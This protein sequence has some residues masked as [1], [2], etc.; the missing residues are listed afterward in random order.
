MFKIGKLRCLLLA[1][2]IGLMGACTFEHDIFSHPRGPWKNSKHY[3]IPLKEGQI[4]S[5]DLTKLPDGKI[6]STFAG[7]TM[8]PNFIQKELLLSSM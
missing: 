2:P 6:S 4:L 5:T 3:A 8:R 7:I 1:L